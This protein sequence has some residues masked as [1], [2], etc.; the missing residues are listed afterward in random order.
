MEE[1]FGNV[2]GVFVGGERFPVIAWAAV[3][4]GPN[5]EV[6]VPVEAIPGKAKPGPSLGGS[7][8]VEVVAD[9]PK[10]EE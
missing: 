6:V 2:Q 5:V 7:R 10:M 1:V 4:H 8:F 3:P 9:S